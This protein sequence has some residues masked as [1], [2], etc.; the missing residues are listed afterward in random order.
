RVVEI[1]TASKTAALNA[2]DSMASY[3][4]RIYLDAD[5]VVSPR[6][7]RALGEALSAPGVHGAVPRP[8]MDLAASSWPVRAFYRINSRL[9][10]FRGRLFGRGVIAIS[11]DARA[12]FG[13]FPE[14]IA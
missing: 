12:R 7:V 11:K 14:I 4:P 5:I 6:L 2:A 1:P 13:A 3:Y 8:E 9:P 10:V